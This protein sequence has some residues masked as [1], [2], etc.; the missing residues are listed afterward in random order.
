[1]HVRFVLVAASIAASRSS[2]AF[3]AAVG[4]F[5]KHETDAIFTSEMFYVALYT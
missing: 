3:A 1:M 5:L 2:S 4:Q